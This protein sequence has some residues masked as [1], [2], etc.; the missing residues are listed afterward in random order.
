MAHTN[1]LLSSLYRSHAVYT[2]PRATLSLIKRLIFLFIPIINECLGLAEAVTTV[3]HQ[4]QNVHLTRSGDTCS[5][6]LKHGLLRFFSLHV[7]YRICIHYAYCAVGATQDYWTHCI[8]ERY[9]P[10]DFK[11][12]LNLY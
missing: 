10:N 7:H 5:Y 11:P 12:K 8:C 4:L 6:S 2:E 3:P 9:A 1:H